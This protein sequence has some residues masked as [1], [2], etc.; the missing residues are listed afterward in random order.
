MIH[1][2][3]ELRYISP[4]IGYGLFASRLIPKGTI[5]FAL[6][7]LDQTFT[8]AQLA[9][10]PEMLR[11][12]VMHF[13]YIGPDHNVILCWDHA[14]FLNHSCAANMYGA[15]YDFEIALRDIEPGEEILDDYGTLGYEVPKCL[16]GA[17]NC[18]GRVRK[19]DPLR[20]SGGMGQSAGV[21]ISGDS[22]RPATP[23]GAGTGERKSPKFWRANS[24]SLPRWPFIRVRR[25]GSIRLR[26]GA[27]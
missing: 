24:L 7:P 8:R 13:H 27:R 2:D 21:R 15:G 3:A 23:L 26:R 5:M 22:P 12:Q 4:T 20:L 25:H 6:D 17:P 9:A 19:D 10:L 16:C 14:R 18:R 1:P 11:K